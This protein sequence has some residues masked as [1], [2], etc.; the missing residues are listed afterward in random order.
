M[1]GKFLLALLRRV[2]LLMFQQTYRIGPNGERVDFYWHDAETMNEPGALEIQRQ[3]FVV[4]WKY[5]AFGIAHAVINVFGTGVAPIIVLTI[6]LTFPEFGTT[7]YLVSLAVFGLLRMF[8][9]H[10]DFRLQNHRYGMAVQLCQQARVAYKFKKYDLAH[11]L[12]QRSIAAATA[13]LP[14]VL[15]D[16]QVG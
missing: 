1:G 12:V 16:V 9:N 11:A 10:Y 2:L 4:R 7:Y 5:E 15:P 3:M 14:V 13:E 8:D 6:G